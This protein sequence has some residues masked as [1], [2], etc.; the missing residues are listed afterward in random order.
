MTHLETKRHLHKELLNIGFHNLY[1]DNDK[2]YQDFL[3]RLTNAKMVNPDLPLNLWLIN[4]Q[5]RLLKEANRPSISI[6]DE[7]Y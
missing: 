3:D 4:E 6:F 2:A 5:H 1:G 7:P